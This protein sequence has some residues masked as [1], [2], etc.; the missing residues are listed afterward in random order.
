M[1]GRPYEIDEDGQVRVEP[2]SGPDLGEIFENIQIH[3]S[4]EELRLRAEH[5]EYY[6]I[7]EEG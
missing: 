5:P 2:F 7:D 1:Q 4:A 3:R 6:E